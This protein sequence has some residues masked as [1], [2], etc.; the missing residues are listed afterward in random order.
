MT[1]YESF[2]NR[3]LSSLAKHSPGQEIQCRST[4]LSQQY[5]IAELDVRECLSASAEE[6]LIRLQAF[7]GEGFRDQDGQT[8]TRT[9]FLNPTGGYYS[10][11]LRTSGREFVELLSK[12]KIGF[13]TSGG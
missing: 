2:K 8:H 13:I 3:F 6:G 7:D 4:S 12:T 9:L 11:S 1:S 5:G 10:V